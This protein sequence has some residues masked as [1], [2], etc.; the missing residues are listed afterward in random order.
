MDNDTK[1]TL[2]CEICGKE[3]KKES[4]KTITDYFS[5]D[6]IVVKHYCL[7]HGPIIVKEAIL[8]QGEK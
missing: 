3:I 6:K 5:N 1:A 2:S 4:T 8:E 7:E